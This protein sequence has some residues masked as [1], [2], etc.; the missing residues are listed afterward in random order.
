MRFHLALGL[1]VALHLF[2]PPA[3]PGA[4]PE[5][6]QKQFSKTWRLAELPPH[7]GW[8]AYIGGDTW[9]GVLGRGAYTIPVEP[10][11]PPGRYRV[12]VRTINTPRLSVTLGG[13]TGEVKLVRNAFSEPL[14]LETKQPADAITLRVDLNAGE[15]A[16]PILQAVFVTADPAETIDAEGVV[17]RAGSAAPAAAAAIPPPPVLTGNYLENSSFEVGPGHG[18]GKFWNDQLD[19]TTPAADGRTSLRIPIVPHLVG[20]DVGWTFQAGRLETKYYRL[21]PGRYEVSAAFRADRPTSGRLFFGLAGHPENPRH[22][23]DGPLLGGGIELGTEW[24][25]VVQVAD[26]TDVPGNLWALRFEGTWRVIEHG[27]RFDTPLAEIQKARAAGQLQAI[28]ESVW[29]DAL[30]VR[31]IGD[32]GAGDGD[33]EQLDEPAPPSGYQIRGGVVEVGVRCDQPGHIL[34]PDE[35]ANVRLM[36]YNPEKRRDVLKVRYRIED[37]NDAPVREAV[38]DVP[39]DGRT[40]AAAQVDVPLDRRGIFRLLTWHEGDPAARDELVYSVLPRNQHLGAVHDAGRTGTDTGFDPRTLA[41][42]KRANCNWVINKHIGRMEL[43]E[44]RAGELITHDDEAQAALDAKM[45]ILGQVFV[46]V[47]PPYLQEFLPP[48]EGAWAPDKKAKY[49]QIWGDFVTRLVS[50]YKDKIRYWEVTNEPYFWATPEDHADILRVASERIRAIDP[51]LHVVAFCSANMPEY[52]PRA[53]RAADPRWYDGISGHFYESRPELLRIIG[54]VIAK[55][56]KTGWQ[57][58]AGPTFPSFYVT[59]PTYQQL[60]GEEHHA[61]PSSRTIRDTFSVGFLQGELRCYGVGRIDHYFHYFTRFANAWPSEPT[62][63]AGSGKEDVEYDGSLRPY[64]VARSVAAHMLDGAKP[65]A[66]WRG[67][68]RVTL[69]LFR[70]DDDTTVGF[71]FSTDG[72]TLRIT[73]KAGGPRWQVTDWFGNALPAAADGGFDVDS[74]PRYFTVRSTPAAAAAVLD[75]GAVSGRFNVAARLLPEAD[76]KFSL[77]LLVHNETPREQTVS[78]GFGGMLGGFAAKA[79][80]VGRLTFKPGEQRFIDLPLLG[81]PAEKLLIVS[82]RTGDGQ[83]VRFPFRPSTTEANRVADLAALGAGPPADAFN[84]DRIRS[85]AGNRMSETDFTPAFRAGHD[86]KHLYLAADVKDDAISPAAAADRIAEGRNDQFWFL[87][88]RPTDRR[89]AAAPPEAFA[90]VPSADDVVIALAPGP[91]G[92]A[93]AEVRR[94]GQPPHRLPATF[95]AVEGGYRLGVAVP[96]TAIGMTPPAGTTSV[97]FNA[98]AFDADGPNVEWKTEWPWAGGPEFEPHNPAGWG[99]LVFRGE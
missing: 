72:R 61:N 87:L 63:R 69:C 49:L 5:P 31:R 45:S 92:K 55:Q 2:A 67:D 84:A 73:P 71:A 23:G 12:Q 7:E 86:D 40:H 27:F 33:A 48:A 85:G 76:G 14:D 57:T 97:P 98:V 93:V 99:E 81:I 15:E 83:T 54:G 79:E 78:L 96:W 89:R 74:F 56:N 65:H 10:P 77:R 82:A 9:P 47:P 28:P 26:V 13:T 38:L 70:R 19:D 75:A 64:A 17:T 1:L 39:L 46:N 29:I 24:K 36:V 11:L 35:P 41:V 53:V 62:R 3:H 25:R 60:A 90:R 91:N 22:S 94:P 21:P 32:A 18:W 44:P 8:S 37:Y 52:F 95:A 58:E 4:E 88:A 51:G 20:G 80:S 50:H 42:L 66:E 34:Y 30:Q 68:P 59:L 43:V 16:N 6:T